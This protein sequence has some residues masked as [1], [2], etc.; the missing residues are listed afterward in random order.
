LD[1]VKGFFAFG[2]FY[3][4]M[5]MEKREMDGWIFLGDDMDGW[6]C[7]LHEKEGAAKR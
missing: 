4:I 2:I 7:V 5:R 1:G 6:S 3:F